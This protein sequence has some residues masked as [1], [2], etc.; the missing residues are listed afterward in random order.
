MTGAAGQA[1]ELRRGSPYQACSSGRTF[2]PCGVEA[3]ARNDLDLMLLHW[4]PFGAQVR[5]DFHE[6]V[7]PAQ[8]TTARAVLSRKAP[9]RNSLSE[10]CD[11]RAPH[12]RL[13]LI[14]HRRHAATSL[15]SVLCTA[16]R[17][18][19]GKRQL[20][21]SS[22]KLSCQQNHCCVTW[23]PASSC[24]GHLGTSLARQERSFAGPG[25]RQ[26]KAIQARQEDDD[27]D[28]EADAGEGTSST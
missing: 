25:L 3:T 9:A 16:A 12:C 22:P 1:A 13:S 4:N 8:R 15:S 5:L 26:C 21:H 6:A 23:R 24:S 18:Q 7:L 19:V 27:E 10:R 14:S 28:E 11:Q 2:R 17:Q 20:R